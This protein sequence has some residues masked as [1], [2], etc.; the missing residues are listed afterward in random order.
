MAGYRSL[1]AFWLGG[2]ASGT[3]APSQATHVVGSIRIYPAVDGSPD[4]YPAVEGRPQQNRR[5]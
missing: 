1:L 3:A 4:V 5:R 2:A